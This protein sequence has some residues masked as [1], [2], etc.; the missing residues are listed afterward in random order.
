M[1]PIMFDVD[2]VLADFVAG[3]TAL[4]HKEFGYGMYGTTSQHTWD[5]GH[6]SPTHVAALWG[7]IDV[8]PTFWRDLPT[9]ISMGET[10]R[11]VDLCASREVYFCTSRPGNRTREQT[12]EW[13]MRAGIDNPAV[14]VLPTLGTKG[15]IA[16]A[17]GASYSIEDKAGN[18]VCIAYMSEAKSYIIDRPYNQFNHDALGSKVK[19]I[20]SVGEY[21]DDIGAGK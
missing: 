18:A 5:F 9:L 21:L 16:N 2:G 11:L 13:L 1:G 17:I 10:G 12:M 20:F 6:M 14:I 4:A 19:R 7:L 15:E 8:H 3:F